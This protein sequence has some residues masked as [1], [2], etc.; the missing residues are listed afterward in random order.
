MT[1]LLEADLEATLAGLGFRRTLRANR[2]ASKQLTLEIDGRWATVTTWGGLENQD[3]LTE[4]VGRPGLWKPS[5]APDGMARAFDLW[6]DVPANTEA[7]ACGPED[8][9][10][11]A[12]ESMLNWALETA[13]GQ[14][15]RGW[16]PEG[17]SSRSELERFIPE[18]GLTVQAGPFV[19][20]GELICDSSRLAISIPVLDHVPEDLG[21]SRVGWLR[22][23]LIDALDRWRMVRVG[24]AGKQQAQVVAE[25]DLTGAPQPLIPDLLRIGLDA[26]RWFVQWLVKPAVLVSD[27][28]TVCDA[29]DVC[30]SALIHERRR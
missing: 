4:F 20:Q 25:V 30:R 5:V 2:Y 29:F 6:L 23:L 15:P 7:D 12:L 16:L 8:R 27:P 17:E 21:A 13:D 3:P 18:G 22:A 28:G 24:F 9:T 10:D 14:V 11:S 26:L 1:L 19:R